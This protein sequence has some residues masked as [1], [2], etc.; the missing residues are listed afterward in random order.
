MAELTA[1]T[2]DD[3]A[4]ERDTITIFLRKS[5]TDPAGKTNFYF[6]IP[7]IADLEAVCPFTIVTTYYERIA[8][9]EGR[10]FR[11]FNVKSKGFTIQAMGRNGIGSI[12]K[13]IA[14]YLDL[15]HPETFTGHCFRMSAAT[16]LADSRASTSTLK[17][18]FRWKSA[19]VAKLWLCIPKQRKIR[20]CKFI[21]H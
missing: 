7:K 20:C 6:K 2:F 5:K 16:A 1:L 11:S 9:K 10:F 13:F 8:R 4:I 15:E 3:V 18:T 14:I 21:K 17:R 12:P 19:T